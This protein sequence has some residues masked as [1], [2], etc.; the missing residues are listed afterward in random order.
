MNSVGVATGGGAGMALAHTIIN[1]AP[2]MDLHEADPKRFDASVNT[3]AALS[4]RVP[5]VLGKHYEITYP[6]RQWQTARG[7][8][9]LPLHERWVAAKAFFGQVFGYE[10]PLYFNCSAPP[11]LTFGKP[12]WF[13]QVGAEV[14]IASNAAAITELSSFGKF[15]VIGAD[16][17]AELDR[18]MTASMKKQP[19]RVMYSL[20]LN[21]AG[22]SKVI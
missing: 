3:V 21:D 20:M 4:A 15:D 10:R 12:E 13:D 7:I 6:G 8:K 16:A 11:K 9:T 14:E 17:E 22:G 5:E 1:G 19:G 2:P 18:I